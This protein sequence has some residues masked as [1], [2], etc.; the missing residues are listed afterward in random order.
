MTQLIQD[1]TQVCRYGPEHKVLP[2]ILAP[3]LVTALALEH[4]DRAAISG[5]EHGQNKNGLLIAIIAR[6]DRLGIV[7][8]K[9]FIF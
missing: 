9:D 7:A 1:S 3:C 2:L 8:G 6:P 5:I 4:A